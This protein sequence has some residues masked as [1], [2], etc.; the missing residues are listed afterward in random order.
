MYVDLSADPLSS[1]GTSF[2]RLIYF[3]QGINRRVLHS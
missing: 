1:Y 3:N 2:H